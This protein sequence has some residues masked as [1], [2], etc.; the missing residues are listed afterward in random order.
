MLTSMQIARGMGE[1]G[2]MRDTQQCCVKIKELH[3]A[4]QK[5][6][7]ANG[8]SGAEPHT[9][10]FYN[11]L[12]AI[13]GG[14]ATSTPTS[15]VDTSEVDDMVDEEEEGEENGRQVSGGTIL[16]CGSQGIMVADRDTG[17]GTSVGNVSF[18]MSAT[19]ESRLSL[20]RRRNRTQED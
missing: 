16:P 13:L 12:H 5:A 3:Q 2:Y 18:D 10:R 9:C 14:D 19:P 1:K 4:Y 17:E 20:I 11:E 8:R 15:N 6:R 7:E